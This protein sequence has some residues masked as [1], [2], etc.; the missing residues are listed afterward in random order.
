MKNDSY[1][2]F[3]NIYLYA[4]FSLFYKYSSK[5]LVQNACKKHVLLEN[6]GKKLL[7]CKQFT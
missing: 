2:F 3:T 4:S 6:I 7:A 5:N 1:E